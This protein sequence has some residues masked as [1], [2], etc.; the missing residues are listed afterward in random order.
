M[1]GCV[2]IHSSPV[3]RSVLPVKPIFQDKIHPVKA[4]I[5]SG[6]DQSFIKTSLAKELGV[7]LW[8]LG[9]PLVTRV[10]NGTKLSLISHVTRLVTVKVLWRTMWNL[11]FCPPWITLMNLLFLASLGCYYTI[12]ISTG[13]MELPSPRVLAAWPLA[14]LQLRLLWSLKSPVLMRQST[15][16]NIPPECLDLCHMF[17]KARAT[18]LLPCQSFDCAIELLPGATPPKGHIN[19]LLLRKK[20]WTSI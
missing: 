4:L 14:C 19:S 9:C 13:V 7:S 5:D 3:K 10:L 8:E 18:S 12:P 16:S 15:F 20:P 1:G 6:E 17:S 2:S 11:S